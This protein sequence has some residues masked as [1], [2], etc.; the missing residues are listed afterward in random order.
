MDTVIINI[1]SGVANV[2]LIGHIDSANAEE[3]EKAIFDYLKANPYESILI[4]A[5]E[6]SYISSAGLRIILKLRKSCENLRII[7][8]SS[9]VFDIFQITGFTEMIPIEKSFRSVSVDG[10]E[11]IGQGSNGVVYRLDDETIIKAYRNPDSLDDIKRETA[12][13]RTAFVSGIPT[14]I[15]FDVVRVNDSYGSVFE[16][17]N[18]KSFAKLLAADP[19]KID[20]YVTLYV[21]L[22]KIIHGTECDSDEITD[23][24]AVAEDWAEFLIPYF[25]DETGSKLLELIKSVPE[26][27]TLLH[28]DYHIKN[29]MMQNEE[30]L[31][32]DMDTLSKGHPIFEFALMFL[33]YQGFGYLNHH[34]TEVFLGVP[35]ELATDFW[36]KSLKLYFGTDDENTIDEI[37]EKS[38]II[39]FARL[40]RRTIR[41]E[42]DTKEGQEIIE[43][44][45]KMITELAPKFD[46][47]DF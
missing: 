24:K 9:E 5:K 25:P 37:K 2:E 20:D 1:N 7:N 45:K 43:N 32:I 23:M 30:V 38:M 11:V 18:A 47:L 27:N 10:C 14:A 33:A 28:G 46:K 39:G 41:R 13:A 15:P 40:M 34:N 42:S 36:N 12:L 17:L 22:L 31:L 4:D 6:L 8:A 26:K 16:L 29:I 19:E 35:Y 21:N 3:T 44:C